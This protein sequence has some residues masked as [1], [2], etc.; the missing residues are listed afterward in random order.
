[1][2]R[3]ESPEQITRS[4]SPDYFEDYL[5][6]EELQQVREDQ[7]KLE[8]DLDEHLPS[9]PDSLVLT[10]LSSNPNITRQMFE[11][12]K[13][14]LC[15]PRLSCNPRV[16]IDLVNSNPELP[17]CR[18]N[19]S[20]NL[21]MTP[22]VIKANPRIRWSYSR[23]SRHPKLTKQFVLEKIMEDWDFGLLAENAVFNLQDLIEISLE[24]ANVRDTLSDTLVDED[25]LRGEETCSDEEDYFDRP[26]CMC[27]A[28]CGLLYGTETPKISVMKKY[29]PFGCY[30]RN[31]NFTFQDIALILDLQ[32]PIHNPEGRE[33]FWH[34]RQIAAHPNIT[35][36]DYR[37][38]QALDLPG[39]KRHS[40][41]PL[42]YYLDNP[43]IRLQDLSHFKDWASGNGVYKSIW[44][45]WIFVKGYPQKRWKY[46]QVFVHPNFTE[47]DLLDA[48]ENT[49]SD[50]GRAVEQSRLPAIYFLRNPNMTWQF[51]DYMKAKGWLDSQNERVSL[52]EMFA[53][54]TGRLEL[55]ERE[56]ELEKFC[57]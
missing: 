41:C 40:E 33:I 49:S 3:S 46:H 38:Y 12:Y 6:R 31:P 50:F 9:N 37:K 30:A 52:H 36:E 16:T 25:D 5:C 27:N 2:S 17:W 57:N 8:Q 29:I 34:N 42:E 4:E 24:L 18:F 7:R 15:Y 53:H 28:N 56:R 1:M 23:L 14:N 22:E 48:M 32:T 11:R 35:L 19:L 55:D 47:D 26:G 45:T 20:D 54:P 39:L 44:L 43:S 21:N 51:Y 10:K 13:N